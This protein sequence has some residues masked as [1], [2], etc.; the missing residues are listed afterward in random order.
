MSARWRRTRSLCAC[1]TRPTFA[2]S[3][4]ASDRVAARDIGRGRTGYVSHAAVTAVTTHRIDAVSLPMLPVTR[5]AMPAWPDTKPEDD[6]LGAARGI[7]F[8]LLFSVPAW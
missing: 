5:A 7:V 8:S 4:L 2:V 3:G 1:S 6:P